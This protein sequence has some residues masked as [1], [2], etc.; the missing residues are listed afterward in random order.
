MTGAGGKERE[1]G[2]GGVAGEGAGGGQ[3]FAQGGAGG[4]ETPVIR[5]FLTQTPE[6][7]TFFPNP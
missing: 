2:G 1:G 4:R 3:V 6:N 5:V 7:I